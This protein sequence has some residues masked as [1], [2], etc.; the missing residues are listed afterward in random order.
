MPV[1]I[2]EGR[3]NVN[4]HVDSKVHQRVRIVALKRKVPL[5]AVLDEALKLWLDAQRGTK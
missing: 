2:P 1:L 5:S 3:Q 4:T